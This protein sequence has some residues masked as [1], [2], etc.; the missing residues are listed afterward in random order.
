MLQKSL[1]A[2]NFGE[3]GSVE[4]RGE[5]TLAVRCCCGC[6][7]VGV[8]RPRSV[9]PIEPPLREGLSSLSSNFSVSSFGL[10]FVSSGLMSFRPAV[11]ALS[12][13]TIPDDPCLLN[14][15]TDLCNPAM[16]IYIWMNRITIRISTDEDGDEE[17]GVVRQ[18]YALVSF[19][20]INIKCNS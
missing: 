17:G 1:Q 19:D 5:L 14:D 11:R 7:R 10:R 15:V 2:P 9:E 13:Q 8:N 16:Y 6:V 18:E 4:G 12:S 20:P 3:G